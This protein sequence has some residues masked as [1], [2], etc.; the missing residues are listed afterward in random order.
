MISSLWDNDCLASSY[1]M[2]I[3][4][5]FHFPF[6]FCAENSFWNI[7][8]PKIRLNSSRK[9]RRRARYAIANWVRISCFMPNVSVSTAR[10]LL[11]LLYYVL[12]MCSKIL[13]PLNDSRNYQNHHRAESSLP[14]LGCCLLF[15][16]L[17]K[18]RLCDLQLRKRLTC[19]LN[20]LKAWQC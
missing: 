20:N 10:N 4:S 7:S 11:V 17:R 8:G 5:Y 15:S 12:N 3:V 9:Q 13:D 18:T 14:Q 2:H 19:A 1:S 16:E 6:A